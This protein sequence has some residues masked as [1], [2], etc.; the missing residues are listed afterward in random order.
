[1]M[2]ALDQA[3]SMIGA[4]SVVGETVC[5]T[6][7]TSMSVC[8]NAKQIPKYKQIGNM[9]SHISPIEG[10]LFLLMWSQAA[11]MVFDWFKNNFCEHVTYEEINNEIKTVPAASDGLLMIPHLRILHV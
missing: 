2:G 3:A 1:M 4:G 8:I 6:T 9:P 5:E 10:Q 11:G 7:G